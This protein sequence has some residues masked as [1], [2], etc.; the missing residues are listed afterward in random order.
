MRKILGF[1]AVFII[2]MTFASAP[3][4]EVGTWWG[5]EGEP[6]FVETADSP[7]LTSCP[8]GLT[9]DWQR[10]VA[11]AS[12]RSVVSGPMTLE[13][14]GKIL[15]LAVD[16]ALNKLTN[17]IGLV[18]VDGFTKLSDLMESDFSLRGKISDLIK[19]SYRIVHE[20]VYKAEGVI[21]VTVEFDLSGKKGLGGTLFPI[22]LGQLFSSSPPT[23]SP[24]SREAASSE[25]YTGLIIDASNLGVEGGLAPRVLSEDGREI[26]SIRK[27]ID[28][29]VLITYGCVDY[30]LASSQ[31]S[32]EV[33]RAGENPLIITAIKK[34]KSTYNCDIVI[35]SNEA[36]NIRKA[37]ESAS[38]LR[39]L[40]VVILL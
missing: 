37:D 6:P 21:E 20:K 24:A 39:K 4:A 22:Y 16:Q 23:P 40:R 28:K 9:V 34:L 2:I 14:R 31:T 36:D 38:F 30:A 7:I 12:G 25:V 13:N 29:S 19:K 8:G 1:A 27:G 35:S 5:E 11:I 15:K 17:T 18:R 10:K 33:S 3:L 26:F 32:D